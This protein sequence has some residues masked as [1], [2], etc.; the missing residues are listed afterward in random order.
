VTYPLFPRSFKIQN[1]TLYIPDQED[2]AGLVDMLA[3]LVPLGLKV[4]QSIIRDKFGQPGSVGGTGTVILRGTCTASGQPGTV[5]GTGRIISVAP[6]VTAV[7]FITA[8]ATLHGRGTA[9]G[10]PG[11]AAGTGRLT[12]VGKATGAGQPG[13]ATGTG[14]LTLTGHAT[15]TAPPA[16]LSGRGDAIDELA[17]ILALAA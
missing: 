17:L 3:K 11:S 15:L 2:L 7:H 13:T 6:P 5:S 14:H 16:R 12:L 8:P 10:Q 9:A 1:F 4:E